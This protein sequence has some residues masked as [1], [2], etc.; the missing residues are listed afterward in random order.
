MN[1]GVGSIAYFNTLVKYRDEELTACCNQRSCGKRNQRII[2]RIFGGV[3][4]SVSFTDGQ[5][6]K[7]AGLVL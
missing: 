5:A 2:K 7:Y 3:Q 6:E 4:C 1:D